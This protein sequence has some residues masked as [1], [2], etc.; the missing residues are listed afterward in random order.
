MEKCDTGNSGLW[1]VGAVCQDR[2]TE[3]GG[4]MGSHSELWGC[5]ALLGDGVAPDEGDGRLGQQ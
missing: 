4:A 2:K 1:V 3:V 5:E